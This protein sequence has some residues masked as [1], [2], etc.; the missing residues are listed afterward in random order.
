MC[1]HKGGLARFKSSQAPVILVKVMYR[2]WSRVCV[3]MCVG[4]NT[5]RDS[6]QGNFH[7]T[8]L[9]RTSHSDSPQA[10]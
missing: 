5:C 6:F 4:I 9:L 7:N 10:R 8:H 1:S 3:C 2:M